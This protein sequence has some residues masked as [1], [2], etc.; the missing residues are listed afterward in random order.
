M[1]IILTGAGGFVGQHF[2]AEY[3]AQYDIQTLSLRNEDWKKQSFAGADA[4]V[5]LAGKAHDMQL[6]SGD[7]YY[8]INTRLTQS[9]YEKAVAEGV[10]HFVYISSTKVYGDEINGVLD[11]NSPLHPTDDYG[12]SKKQ[13][14]EYLRSQTTIPVAI[15]R[16]PLVY[17]AGV[18]GNM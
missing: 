17:G 13:A 6:T 9:L 7:I 15:I 8:E 3:Q 4:I 1:K 14:E 5:H 11:E 18:K 10:K 12:K 16:P 2:L